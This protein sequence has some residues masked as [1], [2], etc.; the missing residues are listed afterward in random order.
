VVMSDMLTIGKL[1]AAANVNVET[2][3]FYQRQGLLPEPPRPPGSIRRYSRSL[4]E[5]I[6]FIKRAKQVG[7][8]LKE[9][10]GLLTLGDGHC[11]QVQQLAEVKLEKIETKLKDLSLM[12]DALSELLVQCREQGDSAHCS[13][14]ER[15]AEGASVGVLSRN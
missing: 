13:L 12:R 6:E 9:I 4:I 3:R 2:I 5:R 8:T 15:L 1:A 14:V 11:K 7:F 10:A